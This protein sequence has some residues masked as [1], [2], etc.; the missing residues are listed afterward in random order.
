MGSEEEGLLE[1]LMGINLYSAYHLTRHI[2]SAMKGNEAIQGS[3]GHIINISSI[4][5]LKAYANGGAYSVSKFAMQGF[6][7]NLR[8]ELM[9]Y[10]IK[11]STINPGATWTDS[12]NGSGVDPQRI[13]QTADIAGIVWSITQ[14][15]PQ[16]VV[17]DIVIRP[18]LGDL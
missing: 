12:W 9:P 5:A 13:L 3:R 18:L 4:A 1:K 15:S 7:K 17:E 10:G 2:L 6:S 8:E 16:A 11:V 14:L